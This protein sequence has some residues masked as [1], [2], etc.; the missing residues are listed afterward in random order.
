VK[1]FGNLS[2]ALGDARSPIVAGVCSGLTNLVLAY[3]LRFTWLGHSGI[4]LAVVAGATV[5]V[6]VLV[7]RLR[8]E[9][10]LYWL[11]DILPDAAR[12]AAASCS[13]GL[14]VYGFLLWGEHLHRALVVPGGILLG[15]VS[16]GCLGMVLFPKR[17]APFTRRLKAIFGQ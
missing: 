8:R 14:I 12:I 2:Y 7:F 15:A 11:I 9:I 16:Y 10:S 17:M 5:N 3:S 4:A 6:L 1:I 13:M